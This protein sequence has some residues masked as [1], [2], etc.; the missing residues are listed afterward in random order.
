M[1][2]TKTLQ[3]GGFYLWKSLSSG[4]SAYFESKQ[5]I[6]LFKRLFHRYL[7]GY[8]E[9]YKIYISSEGYE[10]MV[11]LKSGS[12]LRRVYT[13]ENNKRGRVS[14]LA[15]IIEPWRIVSERIRIFHSVYVKAVNKIRER[16]GVLVQQKYSRYYF[17]G[18]QEFQEYVEDMEKGKREIIGQEN[19]KYRVKVGVKSGVRWGLYRC[20]GWVESIMSIEFQ[21]YVVSKLVNLTIKLH[22]TPSPP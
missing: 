7:I 19:A 6:D 12:V 1:Q 3:A 5:E 16:K 14:R 8:V 13:R 4:N 11:R 10:L 9:I 21:N 15:F 20:K 18:E 2:A 22:S 17:S